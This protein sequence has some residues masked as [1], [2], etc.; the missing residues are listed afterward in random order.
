MKMQAPLQP[1]LVRLPM[2]PRESLFS[3]LVRLSQSNSYISPNTLRDLILGTLDTRKHHQ[4]VNDRLD[5]PLK[6]ETYSRIATL[7]MVDPFTL[8]K[9][10]QHRFVLV[11]TSPPHSVNH[12]ELPDKTSVPCLTNGRE[13]PQI[14]PAD[15]SQF[16]P[17]CLQEH[18]YH[19]LNWMP[20][21]LSACLKHKCLLVD[22]CPNC[23]K[24]V[25]QY[26]VITA[27]CNKCKSDLT[28]AKVI[29]IIDDEIGLRTQQI[30]QSWFMEYTTPEHE[31]PNLSQQSPAVMYRVVE[32]IR[33]S[34]E[35]ENNGNWPY[36]HYPPSYTDILT[37]T[38]R[39]KEQI[40]TPYESYCMYTT[41]CKAI[42]NWPESFLDFLIRY[43]HKESFNAQSTRLNDAIQDE[44]LKGPPQDHLGVLY[45]H[46]AKQRWTYP[47]FKFVQEML[48][49]HIASNYWLDNLPIR[50]SFYKKRPDIFERTKY[51]SVGAAA[52]LLQISLEEVK[53]LQR[54]NLL[55]Q[56]LEG[57]H[58]L[59]DKQE[60]L[61]CY[62][63]WDSLI[64][65][66][67]AGLLMGV[68]PRVVEE[69]A[70]I[71]LL[72]K[73]PSHKIDP[74]RC[75]KPLEIM[76]CLENLSRYVKSCSSQELVE[77]G[78][79]IDF[80]KA[81]QFFFYKESFEAVTILLQ[82]LQGSLIAYHSSEGKFQLKSLLF[83]HQDFQTCVVQLR[84]RSKWLEHQEVRMLL[85][86]KDSSFKI[87]IKSG[88]ILPTVV[89]KCKE[90]FDLVKV[91]EMCSRYITQEE[92]AH[93]LTVSIS[94]LQNWIK[95][96]QVPELLIG[97]P[98]VEE[99]DARIFDKEQ[100]IQWRKEHLTSKEAM[101]VLE[102]TK[103][104]LYR[105]IREGKLRPL[106]TSNGGQYWFLKKAILNL[107][108]KS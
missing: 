56:V 62:K 1:L 38:P 100:V 104:T 14:R 67:K 25:S 93:I 84:D 66:E 26:A 92:A 50:T 42:M 85:G 57:E 70:S 8:Y 45:T 94:T 91:Y 44:L 31:L 68:P 49:Y 48:E 54:N 101:Q 17:K 75:Y 13:Q 63:Y 20:V 105:W 18:P 24:K 79:W 107:R 102:V 2:L 64:T 7:T 73:E 11:L 60:V 29:S 77:K 74:R 61:Y 99:D 15:I 46:W 10:T 36:C 108:S 6:T 39:N 5:Y 89:Y 95:A 58:E 33:S 59:I 97:K 103:T 4:Y 98:E 32:G 65:S 52:K 86:I 21:A 3:F 12:L 83:T 82:I 71:G 106:D 22:Q 37:F 16:C 87:F 47:E 9:R 78:P 28:K 80:A 40:L 90:Y 19:Q 30:L 35:V 55:T 51:V 53:L 88:Y 72:S 27:Q 41:A 76:A 43:S 69:L 81:Q 23:H 96:N 34:V